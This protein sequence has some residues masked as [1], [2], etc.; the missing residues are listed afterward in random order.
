MTDS[1]HRRPPTEAAVLR[2]SRLL[3]EPDL[4]QAEIQA[5]TCPDT[6]AVLRDRL[7]ATFDDFDLQSVS[8][9][10]ACMA[11]EEAL[12]NAVYHGNLEL[13]SSLKEC[14]SGI[15]GKLARERSAV[16]PWRQRKVIVTELATP[17]GLWLTIR[18]EGP[19]FDVQEALRRPVDP[20]ALLASGRGLVMMRAFSDD[21]VFNVPG[22]EVTLVFYS[23]RNREI[24]DLL[25]ARHR[26]RESTHQRTVI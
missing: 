16:E 6:I 8:L 2:E 20:E 19:G 17:F 13:D 11:I 4:R 14:G 22:N 9:P 26:T 3:D 21:L 12:A 5:H 15:F 1:P 23:R 10:Q 24:R 18:D 7:L 25:R